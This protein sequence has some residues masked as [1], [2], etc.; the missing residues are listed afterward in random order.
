MDK[1]SVNKISGE[2]ALANTPLLT[3][4]CP[5]MHK[6]AFGRLEVF[7]GFKQA[8]HYLE[9]AHQGA[10]KILVTPEIDWSWTRI[11]EYFEGVITDQGTRVS[12][13]AE[14][15][16]LMNKPGV[17]G[18]KTATEILNSGTQAHIV[19]HG[20]VALVYLIGENP[21]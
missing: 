17:L 7:L 15:L 13:A 20:N 4:E 1:T 11:L 19:C 14:V 6:V 21:R 2:K 12:R 10:S 8:N 9:T 18:A 3:G 5:T 16:T